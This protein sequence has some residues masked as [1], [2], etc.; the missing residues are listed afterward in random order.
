LKVKRITR[1]IPLYK[2]AEEARIVRKKNSL[3]LK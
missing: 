1:D 2:E 3:E